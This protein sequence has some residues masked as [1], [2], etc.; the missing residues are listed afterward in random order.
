RR[1]RRSASQRQNGNLAAASR[2]RITIKVTDG[3][4]AWIGFPAL[5]LVLGPEPIKLRLAQRPL[6]ALA[7][8]VVGIFLIPRRDQPAESISA[9]IGGRFTPAL[10]QAFGAPKLVQHFV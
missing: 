1:S 7:V 2:G 9:T 5:G 3:L 8:I 6:P 10:D 4:V